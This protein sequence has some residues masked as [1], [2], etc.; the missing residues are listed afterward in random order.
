M[1]PDDFNGIF[2]GTPAVDFNNLYSWR[3][4]FYPITGSINSSDF[5]TASSWQT[6][7][8]NEVLRQCDGL[9]GVMD[10]IIQD[11]NLCVFRPEA[12]MCTG[13]SST[14]CLT[15]TQV[16]KVRQIFSPL[17]GSDGKLI[18]PAMQPG[19]EIVSATGLYAGVPWLLSQ[20]WV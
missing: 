17:Y 14:N 20:V 5:I 7:I 16:E 11:P 10:G 4:N 19:S 15:P 13:N 9:D 8:H 12:I 2:A 6:L 1:F 3:A 18:Y